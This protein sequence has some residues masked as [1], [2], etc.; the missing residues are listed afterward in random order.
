M[1]NSL[2]NQHEKACISLVIFITWNQK[3]K[4]TGLLGLRTPKSLRMGSAFSP[5]GRLESHR[6]C[7]CPSKES[8]GPKAQAGFSDVECKKYVMRDL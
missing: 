4:F 1:G 8:A 6:A 3:V 7:R 2:L 5:L